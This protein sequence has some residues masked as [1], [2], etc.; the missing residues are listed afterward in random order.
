MRYDRDWS[1]AN[2]SVSWE[3]SFVSCPRKHQERASIAAAA[4]FGSI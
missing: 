3:R 4:L 2:R 1:L